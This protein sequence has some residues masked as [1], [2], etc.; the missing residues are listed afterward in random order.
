MVLL[1]EVRIF[2]RNVS[3]ITVD[4]LNMNLEMI[5]NQSWVS[6]GYACKG[7]K[8]SKTSEVTTKGKTFLMADM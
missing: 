2:S 7:S 6:V 3:T 5:V 4:A 8:R 1:N